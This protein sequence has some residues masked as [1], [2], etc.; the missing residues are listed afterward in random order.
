MK[1]FQFHPES[2]HSIL[3]VGG[4]HMIPFKLTGLQ[5]PDVLV[6]SFHGATNRQKIALPRF[7][8][9]PNA[10]SRA[11]YLSICD[12]TLYMNKALRLGWYSG[13]HTFPLRSILEE[14]LSNTIA[15]LTPRRV[16]F[17]GSSGGGYAALLYAKSVTG[18]IALTIN[19]HTNFLSYYSGHV[20]DYLSACWPLVSLADYNTHNTIL[21]D[22]ANLYK[23]NP[24]NVTVVMVCS[25]GD[26]FHFVNHVSRFIGRVG[27]STR[28][29]IILA[30]DFF[31][32]MGHSGSIPPNVIT[33]WFNAVLSAETTEP[34]KILVAYCDKRSPPAKAVPRPSVTSHTLDVDPR[35]LKRADILRAFH[36]HKPIED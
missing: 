10:G 8:S 32:I 20:N 18:A 30:S 15:R 24:E 3:E 22:L 11:A 27:D 7:Q 6:V 29:R 9:A 14:L 4:G 5:D 13:S 2:D 26:R 33:R 36:L 17:F 34:E 19:P 25:A 35:D 31:G 12:P 21:C 1:S 23:D 16:I 28:S